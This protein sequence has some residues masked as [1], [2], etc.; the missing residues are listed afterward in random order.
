MSV[1]A[2]LVLGADVGSPVVSTLVVP[3]P[4]GLA[5]VSG[6]ALLVGTTH[7]G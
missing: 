6:F 3:T 4:G 7:V 5:L 2:P 1:A